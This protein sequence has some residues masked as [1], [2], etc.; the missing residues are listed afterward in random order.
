MSWTLFIE[1]T[2]KVLTNISVTFIQAGFAAWAASGFSTDKVV[3]A[4]VL[5]AGAS[6]AWN[7]VLKP[8]LVKY[9]WLKG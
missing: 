3:L 9:G 8:I 5:G 6:A 2:A 7:L 4:G 1:P